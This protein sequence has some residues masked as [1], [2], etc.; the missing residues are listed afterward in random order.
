MVDEGDLQRLGAG[1]A[2]RYR[3]AVRTVVAAGTWARS[4]LAE[5]RAWQHVRATIYGRTKRANIRSI[6]HYAVTEMV[7]NAID[8]SAGTVVAVR[9]MDQQAGLAFEV[10]DDGVGIFAHIMKT[11]G[12]RTPFEAIA[13]LQKGKV[14]T[15]P[16]AHSGEGI[17]FTSRMSDRMTIESGTTRWLVD[18]RIQD[19]SIETAARRRGTLVHFEISKTATRTTAG[20]FGAHTNADLGFSR[21]RTSI[22]LF[23]DGDEIVSRSEARRLL[24]GL[25]RFAEVELD[26][27]HVQGI[28]QGFA[29]EVFRVWQRDHPMTRLTV[30]NANQAVHFMIDRA[31]AG[32]TTPLRSQSESTL[33]DGRPGV[34]IRVGDTTKTSG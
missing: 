6:L 27:R 4:G 19:Q 32:A 30:A 26:F 16:Q 10:E 23:R 12:L 21:T 8:H 9:V 1:R 34:N 15:A 2:T 7:N 5:E 18:N 25:E 11:R 17:F 13:E 3:R 28:G 20:V 14:T 31:R 22:K 33:V 24:T 29:D